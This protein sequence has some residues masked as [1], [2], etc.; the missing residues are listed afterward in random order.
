[1]AYLASLG[2]DD[3]NLSFVVAACARP[4]RAGDKAR[5][6][7][8]AAED[9]RNVRRLSADFMMFLPIAFFG[10]RLMRAALLASH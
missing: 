3:D 10:A 4:I 1:L 2:S 9:R 6:A 5:P 7:V 8:V